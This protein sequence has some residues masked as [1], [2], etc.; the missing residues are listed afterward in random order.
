M[1]I[2]LMWTLCTGCP[3]SN[4]NKNRKLLFDNNMNFPDF[5]KQTHDGVSYSLPSMFTEYYNPDFTLEKNN[6][7]AWQVYDLD[8]YF[9][10][11]TFVNVDIDKFKFI[12]DSEETDLLALQKHYVHMREN[13][14]Y[15]YET[16]E[17][18]KLKL[19]IANGYIQAITGSTYSDGDVL[20]Y[21]TSSIKVGDEYY[22]LQ[23]IGAE[24]NM[25]YLFDDFIQIINSVH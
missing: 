24:E 6:A 5:I 22:V 4:R 19:S 7:S 15:Q 14:L 3:P 11:E 2:I 1:S 8:I 13:S 16:S 9:S 10:I 18:K 20:I 21:F 12:S 17:I 23:L 25:S